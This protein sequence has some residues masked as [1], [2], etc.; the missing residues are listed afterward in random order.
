[1]TEGVTYAKLETDA[2]ERFVR[3]RRILG[4]SSFGINLIVLRPGER[5]RI[6]RHGRQEEVYLV[7]E[8]TLSLGVEGEERDLE[9]GEI[10]RV[11]P[12]VRRQLV[13]RGPGRCAVLA[14]GGDGEHA[15]RDGI[16]YVSWEATEG[17]PPQ[18]T[19]LPGDL[20][21]SERRR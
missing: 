15:G 12:E 16:A 6:H 18:Q 7:L 5:G 21:E 20:P 10:V 14:L 17:A 4:V 11:G 3:L 13:N 1:M 9:E 19:P 8:G 2:P